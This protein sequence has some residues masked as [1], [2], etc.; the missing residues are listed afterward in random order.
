MIKKYL[1][2]K[3]AESDSG[4]MLGIVIGSLFLVL[5]LFPVFVFIM[6]TAI[7]GAVVIGVPSAVIGGVAQEMDDIELKL[8]EEEINK[9]GQH[10][11]HNNGFDFVY[12]NQCDPRWK[13]DMYGSLTIG[14]SG[15]GPSCMA[16]IVASFLKDNENINPKTMCDLSRRIGGYNA[17]Y[18][19]SNHSV[20]PLIAEYYGLTC[21][22]VGTDFNKV[23]EALETGNKLAVVI[24]APSDWTS[25]GHFIVLRGAEDG[26]VIIADPAST[27]RSNVYWSK[28]DILKRAR[29]S[30]GAGGPYWIISYSAS[31]K[32]QNARD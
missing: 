9:G 27:D 31:D 1:L 11:Y 15:C 19:C 7:S 16:M 18:Q 8:T 6:V 5:F 10:Q 22:G 4:K 21:E 25:A 24:L 3:A 13:N 29:T 26:K 28:Q 14:Y 17:T 20:V 12:F 2:K 23:Y 30:A 32:L